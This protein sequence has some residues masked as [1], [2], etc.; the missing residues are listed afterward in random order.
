MKSPPRVA[1][2]YHDLSTKGGAENLSVWLAYTL[3]VRGYEVT[4]F[5]S[6]Y[7]PALWPKRFLSCFSVHLLPNLSKGCIFQ[8]S[9]ML[10]R[11][12]FGR[13]L[14]KALRGYDVIVVNN[15]PSIQWVHLAK[16]RGGDFGKV[17]WLCQ[18]PT[19]RLFGHVT[20]R[21]LLD[22]KT[23]CNGNGYNGHISE[24]V[25]KHRLAEQ[26]RARKH[27]RNARWEIDA[28]STAS[29]IV[30][31]SRFT[32]EHVEK[33]YS[34]KPEVIYPG[35]FSVNAE[36]AAQSK[37]AEGNYIGYVGRLSTKKN[38][39]N[40]IEAFRILCER[41]ASDG[42]SLKIVGEGPESSTLQKKVSDYRLQ[43]RVSFLGKLS[44]EQLG[45][46]YAHARL[47]VYA[48]IDEPFGLVPLES[49]YY[50]TP[51]IA[52]DHGGPAEVLTYGENAYL[53]NP[54]DPEEMAEAITRCVWNEDEARGL[55]EK[56]HE[57]VKSSFMFDR[58]VSQLVGFFE[59][60][61][62]S[63]S[64]TLGRS[65][66]P[67]AEATAGSLVNKERSRDLAE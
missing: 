48:P 34:R 65:R 22:Y 38:V 62:E 59:G 19:R 9:N 56:G 20:D 64:E 50:K 18:E 27:A 3:A 11:R 42:L 43:E 29:V 47:C 52:S 23:Y 67:I 17:L 16:K 8:K 37:P 39:H 30:A 57:L 45:K 51:V 40:V 35:V 46:F 26:K 63:P 21:H 49:L 58:F 7:D 41:R 12:V 25:R 31:N 55:A 66:E 5:T 44:D 13:Y 32:A 10:K 60:K 6:S 15:N 2:V 61:K 28:A 4:L 14:S 33:V 36:R 54:F 24:A 1:L 53:V